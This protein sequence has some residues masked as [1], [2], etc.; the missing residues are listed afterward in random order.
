MDKEIVVR[1]AVGSRMSS[2]VLM[3]VL[4]GCFQTPAPRPPTSTKSA[5]SGATS[6]PIGA[7]KLTAS[8]ILQRVLNTYR[9]A[10]SYQDEGI[11]RLEFRQGGQQQGDQWPCAVKFVRPNKLS[12]AAYQATVKCD[13]RE[14][15]ANITDE[16]S[17]DLDGQ[18]LVRPAPQE[19]KLIDLA[20][21]EIL[22]GIISSELR[23]QPI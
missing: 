3:T 1:I 20:S 14:L 23:R 7:G 8:Q 6:I 21:D 10:A 15:V 19:L 18:F 5:S 11:V 16:A 12:L 2:L 4:V 9:G 13:G 17:G 22:Y